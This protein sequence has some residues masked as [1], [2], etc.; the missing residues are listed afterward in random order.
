MF[1]FFEF[2]IGHFVFVFDLI[3]INVVFLQTRFWIEQ[4]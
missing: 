2:V 1:E 3:G 4:E